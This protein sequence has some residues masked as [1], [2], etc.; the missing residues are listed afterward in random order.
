[1]PDGVKVV[2]QWLLDCSR[3]FAARTDELD[4]LDKELGDGDHGTNMRR[5]FAA[6]ETLDLNQNTRAA[7]ALRHVG[8]ALVQNVGGA[9]GPLFGTFFLRAGA[10]WDPSLTTAGIARAVRA[11]VDGVI[12]RG[13]AQAGDKTMVDALL[14]AAESLE[15]SPAAGEDMTSALA[16]AADAAEAGRDATVDMVARRGRA[17]LKADRS[18]GIIDPGAV[19]M[20]LI[21]R[22]AVRHIG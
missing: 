5:G 22:T 3:E 17:A 16:R 12:A 9:S 7:D 1:M 13:K 21:L 14:P 19:S 6:A 4:E 11:G 2:A 10:A 18:V 15:A 8:M 20:A